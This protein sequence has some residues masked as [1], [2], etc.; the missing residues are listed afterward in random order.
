MKNYT[1]RNFRKYKNADGTYTYIITVDDEKVEVSEVIYNAY[2]EGG[3]KME[4][5]EHN[6]KHSRV[7]K[8]R[9]SYAIRDEHGNT[10]LISE[11]EVSLDMLIAD[12]WEF[13]SSAPSPESAVIDRMQIEDLY[14]SLDLLTDD[15]RELI[16]SLFFDGMTEREYAGL[17][18]IAQKNVN[19]KKQRVLQKLKN[20]LSI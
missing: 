15:E 10:T 7:L 18:G 17:I 14:S 13:P 8:D 1:D 19:K 9:N 4:N 11:R 12:D 6:L 2:A 5:M 20:Y 16:H 3:Y